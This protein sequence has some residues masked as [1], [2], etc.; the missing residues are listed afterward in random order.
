ML[1]Q[2]FKDASSSIRNLKIK[3]RLE[4][5]YNFLEQAKVSNRCHEKSA[6]TLF[7]FIVFSS[8]VCYP[9]FVHGFAR[10]DCQNK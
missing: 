10:F 5:K 9:A 8:C 7:F 6:T 3:I 2:I 1:L 4:Y